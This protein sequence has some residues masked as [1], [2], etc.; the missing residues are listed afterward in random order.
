MAIIEE[1]YIVRANDITVEDG[2]HNLEYY[3]KSAD[4]HVQNTHIVNQMVF[5]SL[6]NVASNFSHNMSAWTGGGYGLNFIDSDGNSGTSKSANTIDS[7]TLT[8]GET[9]LA[10]LTEEEITSA[11][12]KGWTLQ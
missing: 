9:Y 10:Y 12:A 5:S 3:F 4:A 7:S 11:V 8:L 1:S 6:K 2:T